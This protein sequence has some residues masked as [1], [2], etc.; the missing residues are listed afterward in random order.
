MSLIPSES[1]SFPEPLEANIR[2]P[3][4]KN[5]EHSTAPS[6]KVEKSRAREMSSPK[7]LVSKNRIIS[8]RKPRKGRAQRLTPSRPAVALAEAPVVR[9]KSN[10]ASWIDNSGALDQSSRRRRLKLVRFII[11]ESVALLALIVL[12]KLGMSHP[13][14]GDPLRPWFRT[15]TVLAALPVGIIPILF[16]GLPPSLPRTKH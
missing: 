16:Y 8:L 5:R 6:P 12:A 13:F 1:Y 4:V 3:R 2:P 9:K 7:K 10:G 14:P 11:F 15:M